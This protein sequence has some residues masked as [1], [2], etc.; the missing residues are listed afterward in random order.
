MTI[1][2]TSDHGGFEDKE[3]LKQLLL[4]QGHTVEDLGPAQLE[5]TDD[6]PDFG[7][8][9]GERVASEPGSMGVALCRNGQGICV[10]ANKVTG[11]RAVTVFHPGMAA[12]T[13]TDD[14]ANVLCLSADHLDME[15]IRAIVTR[16]LDTPFSGDER[17]IRRLAKIAD[18]ESHR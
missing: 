5:P 2:I 9:L 1:Y 14:D 11:I 8:A 15:Q 6:Y 17:H 16:W 13:R 18:Y 3:T 7:I 10:A 4:E 12:S